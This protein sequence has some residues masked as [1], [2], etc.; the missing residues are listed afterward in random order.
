MEI[1]DLRLAVEGL[2][3][4]FAK[5][6]PEFPHWYVVRSPEN[7]ATYVALF[8]AIHEHGY[9]AT[10]GGRRYKYLQLGDGFKYWAMTTDI[11]ASRIINRDEVT[12]GT[13]DG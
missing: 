9:A 7:E 5:T 12:P 8:H 1:E 2:S 10:F 3:F 4:R 6:M 13:N 11:R